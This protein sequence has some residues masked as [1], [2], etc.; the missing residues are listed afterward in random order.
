VPTALTSDG[1]S[2]YFADQKDEQETRFFARS[3]D[4]ATLSL[5]VAEPYIG[6]RVSVTTDG[7]FL[8]YFASDDGGSSL[9]HLKRVPVG[10]GAVEKIASADY[11][12]GNLA[13][14]DTYVYWLTL[15]PAEVGGDG[16]G[17]TSTTLWRAAKAGGNPEQLIAPTD[18]W[19]I[20]L[21][22]G[23]KSIFFATRLN[24]ERDEWGKLI[25]HYTLYWVARDGGNPVLFDTSTTAPDPF[26]VSEDKLYWTRDGAV[27]SFA[28]SAGT[29]S[30][31][32]RP[33]TDTNLYAGAT[34]LLSDGANLYAIWNTRTDT[35]DGMLFRF[36]LS[37]GS[38]EA[39]TKNGQLNC[40]TVGMAINS[41]SVVVL[42]SDQDSQGD[43]QDVFT[44]FAK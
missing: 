40:T 44:T 14:D 31:I 28:P 18:G 42:S 8:Y 3:F 5:L 12:D 41:S 11:L 22:V 1:Q 38:S 7:T 21:A 17:P 36:S 2:L 16:S 33:V 23:G 10:G 6:G 13:I 29:P 43:N 34:A 4:G 32:T 9:V 19:P 25:W 26:L 15:P 35:C 37:T 30:V 39:V 24:S 20:G 27:Y